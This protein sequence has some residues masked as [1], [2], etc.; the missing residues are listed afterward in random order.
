V[1]Y[2]DKGAILGLLL[3][4]EIRNKSS[5]AKSLDDVLRHLYQE[6]FKKGRN[7]TPDDFQKT[8]EMMAGSSLDQ[9]FSKYVR[10]REELDY[11]ASLAAAGLKLDR[12]IRTEGSKP[13]ERVFFGADTAQEGDRLIVRR[14]YVGSPAYD[15]GLNTGDQIIA[16]NNMRVTK[17][18]FDGRMA[19]QKPGELINLTI[20]RF[21]DLSTLL[22][23]LGGRTEG[24]YRI[25]P[26]EN[27]TELQKKVYQSWLGI[28]SPA[29]R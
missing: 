29:P 15:Q 20:F 27:A 21:D 24:T 2:Y 22:I 26:V 3:D 17:E 5:N 4:L 23:K 25:V 19:Q 18:L 6:F 7:Y 28:S 11:N 9:F 8:A 16:L 14:V 13:I 12:G 1:S 10:A